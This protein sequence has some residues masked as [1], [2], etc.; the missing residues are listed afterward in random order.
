MMRT[1]CPREGEVFDMVRAREEA[2]A[3]GEELIMHVRQCDVCRDVLTVG[4]ALRDDRDRADADV[5]VPA[6]GQVWWRAA[7]RARLEA[8]HAAARPITWVHGMAGASAIGLALGVAGIVWPS[9]RQA[10]SWAADRFPVLEP[11]TVGALTVLADAARQSLPIAIG[12][13][14]CLVLAPLALY[15]AFSDWGE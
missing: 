9:V 11:E 10:A 8:T 4:T 14:G 1:D 15:V 2:S 13:A 7:V 12:V 5:H 6:A 3:A